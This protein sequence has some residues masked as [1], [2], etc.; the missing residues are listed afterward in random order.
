MKSLCNPNVDIVSV[1]AIKN[2]KCVGVHESRQQHNVSTNFQKG[3]TTVGRRCRESKQADKQQYDI[4]RNAIQKLEFCWNTPTIVNT[5]WST[6][7]CWNEGGFKQEVCM[8]L[9]SPR[10][11][12]M[13]HCFRELETLR[14]RAK[15][16]LTRSR[17]QNRRESHRNSI[18]GLEGRYHQAWNPQT[19]PNNPQCHHCMHIMY[20]PVAFF[21]T[22]TM[23]AYR[24]L[25]FRGVGG[26]FSQI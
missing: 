9:V 25:A 22:L 4:Q 24:T 3:Q 2:T 11:L 21:C 17:R 19:Q 14:F 5:K 16:L 20:G 13:R 6:G 23:I 10:L 7:S 26:K 15:P 12:S 1:L 8:V 18:F